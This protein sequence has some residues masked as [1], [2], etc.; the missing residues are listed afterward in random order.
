VCGVVVV[1]GGGV[2]GAGVR[3]ADAA[4]ADVVV[5][6]GVAVDVI[7]PARSLLVVLRLLVLVP[8][9]VLVLSLL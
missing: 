8:L 3:V 5:A 4:G 9:F 6:A 1:V 2:A 7:V